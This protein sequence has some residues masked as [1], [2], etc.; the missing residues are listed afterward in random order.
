MERAIADFFEPGAELHIP[1]PRAALEHAG[2]DLAN[3]FREN[4]LA[5]PSLAETTG[6]DPLQQRPGLK[7]ERFQAHALRERTVAENAHA[8]RDF[9]P[10]QSRA[11]ERVRPN[12]LQLRVRGERNLF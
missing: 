9:H 3:A 11:P 12:Q 2:A 8:A 10:L 1:K 4:H 5:E 7:N 6:P